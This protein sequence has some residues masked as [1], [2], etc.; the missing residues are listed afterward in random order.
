MYGSIL[1]IGVVAIMS[2]NP[3]KGD[4]AKDDLE[5][6][7]GDWTLVSTETKGKK[8]TAE[9]F[10][11]FSRKVT[12]ENYSVT[13][14][15]EGGVQ[16]VGIK[17]IN[18]DSSKSPKAID[19]EMT[20]G[21]AKGKTFRGIYKFEDDTQVICLAAPD[22]DRPAKFDSKEG[23]VTVWKR[24]K[25]PAE[26]KAITPDL[27]QIKDGKVW[28][29]INVDCE[30][31][32]EDGK[33]VVRLKP[34][35]KPNTPGEMGLALLEGLEFTEGTL[36]VD[37]KGRGKI[38]TS[39]LGLAFS[40]LDGKVFEAVYF[41]PFNFMRDDELFRARAVQYISWPA[42]PWEKLR[43]E[44]PGVFESAV[45][46]VPDPSGWFHARIEVTKKKVRVWVEDAKEPSLVVDR[47]ASREKGKIGL[48]VDNREC[49]FSN[50][51]IVS[52]N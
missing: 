39:F 34:K 11:E 8:R 4:V 23:T 28:N 10:K 48:W 51:K 20:E 9:D 12:G 52:A 2:L 21:P 6:M 13:I 38:E 1:L 31:A 26:E 14:E 30:T 43:K 50:L 19:V 25:S 15:D 44:K 49:S 22:L 33:R 45:K 3:F 18:L 24:A 27:S 35:G 16:T 47:L 7:K 5:K 46:P 40:A 36:E 17:I 41:R 37:L 32:T 29:L 42:D